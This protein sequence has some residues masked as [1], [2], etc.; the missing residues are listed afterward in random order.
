MTIYNQDPDVLRWG[1]HLLDV[2]SISNAGSC[3]SVTQFD[4]DLSSVEYVREGYVEAEQPGYVNTENDELIAHAFLEER[5]RLALEE[6]SGAP[7]SGNERLQ[8]SVLTH[9]WLAPL[10]R[11]TYVIQKRLKYVI[12]FFRN[13]GRE[14]GQQLEDQ[15]EVKIHDEVGKGY[16]CSSPGEKSGLMMMCIC[17][18]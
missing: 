1:L 18:T 13:T 7:T 9:D 5:S 16:S 12:K 15:K 8:A 4:P 6:A 17:Y 2:C 14:N 3:G 11:L 10:K